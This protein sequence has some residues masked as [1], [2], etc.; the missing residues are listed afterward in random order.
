METGQAAPQPAAAP[1][2]PASPP[3]SSDDEPEE[4]EVPA[5]PPKKPSKLLSRLEEF[6]RTHPV[7]PRGRAA[8]RGVMSKRQP[9]RRATVS[10]VHEQLDEATASL[11]GEIEALRAELA[12]LKPKSGAAPPKRVERALAPALAGHVAPAAAAPVAA[13]PVAAA[14]AAARLNV[15]AL[16]RSAPLTLGG[17][18]IHRPGAQYRRERLQF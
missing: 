8:R 15:G 6:K 16:L 7:A 17:G 1:T 14:P 18:A 11:R 13:A 12:A 4:A 2:E 10:E 5:P 3:S 9:Q